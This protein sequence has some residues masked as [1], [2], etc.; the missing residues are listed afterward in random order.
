MKQRITVEDLE[1]LTE[2]QKQRLREWWKPQSG[3]FMY[4]LRRG[5]QVLINY[6]GDGISDD[7][8]VHVD[9]IIGEEL[10]TKGDC[11][12][13]LNIGQMI[14]LLEEGKMATEIIDIKSPRGLFNTY[15]VWYGNGDFPKKYEANE[16]CNA[17]WQAVKQILKEE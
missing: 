7:V 5:K 16:L 9:Y 6:I 15:F 10:Y 2:E 14:E 8:I 3:D 4:Y 13:L 1:Q 11:L 12:P 17:L